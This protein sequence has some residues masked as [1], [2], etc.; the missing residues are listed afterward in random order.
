MCPLV[1]SSNAL[2]SS[3]II[4]TAS[5]WAANWIDCN[6]HT[7]RYLINIYKHTPCGTPKFTKKVVFVNKIH[8][9][10]FKVWQICHFVLLWKTLCCSKYPSIPLCTSH[11]MHC[12]LSW[13]QNT[14][15][16][17][18]C[19]MCCQYQDSTHYHRMLL[20]FRLLSRRLHCDKHWQS[21]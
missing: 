15:P 19:A 3:C 5:T 21:Q 6:F 13:H 14:L 11:C 2:V 12:P 9:F 4:A 16:R 20:R 7:T 17:C 1:A 18:H 8:G 10:C